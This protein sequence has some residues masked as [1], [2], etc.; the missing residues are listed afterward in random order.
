MNSTK[1]AKGFTLF[2]LIVVLVIAGMTISIVAPRLVNSLGK[3][4]A[5]T[6]AKKIAAALR[7]ARSKAASEKIPYVAVFDFNANQLVVKKYLKEKDALEKNRVQRY[8]L[9]EDVHLNHGIS[10]SGNIYRSE[11]FYI[12]FYPGGGSSGGKITISDNRE[13]ELTIK[14]N[15]ITGIVQLS[16]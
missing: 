9:P 1:G 6:A 7:Y 11:P 2:E 4:N 12:I 10:V 5:K 3:M 15:F 14:I 13:R 16:E 8:S